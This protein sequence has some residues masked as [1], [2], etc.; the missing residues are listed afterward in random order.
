MKSLYFTIDAIRN[1]TKQSSENSPTH[2]MLNNDILSFV[3]MG[4][5]TT[6]KKLN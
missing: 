3:G 2:I 6:T 4:E 1:S 5:K